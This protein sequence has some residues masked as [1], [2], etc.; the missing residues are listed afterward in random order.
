MVSEMLLEVTRVD[1]SSKRLGKYV[2]HGLGM[3]KD[4]VPRQFYQKMIDVS[5]CLPKDV[6]S[7]GQFGG[8]CSSASSASAIIPFAPFYS[9]IP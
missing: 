3:K 8:R 4:P 9:Y 1:N 5:V 2:R 6:S 7:W